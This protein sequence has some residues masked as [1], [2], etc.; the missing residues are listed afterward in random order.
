MHVIRDFHQEIKRLADGE[1]IHIEWM[2]EVLMH[3]ADYDDMLCWILLDSIRDTLKLVKLN[4]HVQL[5]VSDDFD[6]VVTG[7]KQRGSVTVFKDAMIS[8]N[9]WLQDLSLMTLPNRHSYPYLRSCHV[10]GRTHILVRSREFVEVFSWSLPQI[11]RPETRLDRED[12]R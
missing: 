3:D 9:R 8:V 6:G 2:P 10:G 7:W 12:E 11:S 5:P 1:R 4:V